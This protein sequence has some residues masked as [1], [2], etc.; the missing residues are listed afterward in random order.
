LVL[1]ERA[2]RPSEFVRPRTW[3]PPSAGF[4]FGRGPHRRKPQP[5]L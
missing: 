2:L 1:A 3:A 5:W 4:S